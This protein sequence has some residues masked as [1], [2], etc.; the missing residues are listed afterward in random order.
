MSSK[1]NHV[2]M[3]SANYA[4]ESKF[5]EAVFGMRNSPK[6]RPARAV[7]IGDGYVG[8][9]INPRR[10]GRPSRLD[11]FGI[12]VDDLESTVARIR[13]RHPEVEVL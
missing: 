2:A 11:H 3:M 9:N 10:A 12:Q 4:L 13:E 8:M 6:A 7:S 1:I 5:Y